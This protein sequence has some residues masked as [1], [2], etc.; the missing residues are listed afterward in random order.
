MSRSK[1]RWLTES[2]PSLVEHRK[3]RHPDWQDACTII[4]ALQP[5]LMHAPEVYLSEIEQC[6]FFLALTQTNPEEKDPER[7]IWTLHLV[8]PEEEEKTDAKPV[9]NQ[10]FQMGDGAILLSRY[11]TE[12]REEINDVLATFMCDFPDAAFSVMGGLPLV[13]RGERFPDRFV[14]LNN[15]KEARAR[16]VRKFAIML[17]RGQTADKKPASK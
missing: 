4:K 8:E 2:I 7:L 5:T 9:D 1:P 16:Q 10:V 15:F 13:I 3:L 6:Q 11:Q 12:D 17:P 14:T